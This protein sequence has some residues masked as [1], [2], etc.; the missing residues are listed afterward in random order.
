MD[1]QTDFIT[2]DKGNYIYRLTK[3]NQI[4]LHFYS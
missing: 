2:L 4:L 3:T 1:E